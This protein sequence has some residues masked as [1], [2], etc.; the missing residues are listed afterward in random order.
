MIPELAAAGLDGLECYYQGYDTDRVDQLVAQARAHDL[1]PTGGSDYHGFP[2]SGHTEVVNF[3]GSVEVPAS[4]L[5]EL[6]ARL[7]SRRRSA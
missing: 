5:D 2:L 6:E 3:P 7:A 1:V 4:V